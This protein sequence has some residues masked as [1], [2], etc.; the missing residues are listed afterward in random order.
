MGRWL[1][2]S[3]PPRCITSSRGIIEI[4]IE[5]SIASNLRITSAFTFYTNH[6]LEE[7]GPDQGII[8]CACDYYWRQTRWVIPYIALSSSENAP[9]PRSEHVEPSPH[10]KQP[11]VVSNYACACKTGAPNLRST[12]SVASIACVVATAVG[13]S[14]LPR[15][16]SERKDCPRGGQE[17]PP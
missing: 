17:T 13:M 14:C 4:C 12:H 10:R 7:F 15:W 3:T 1:C 16:R 11:R 5:P 8:S 6:M 9:C 2:L